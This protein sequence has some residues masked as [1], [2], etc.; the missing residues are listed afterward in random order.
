V[1]RVR[2]SATLLMI[3]RESSGL[4]QSSQMLVFGNKG[5]HFCSFRVVAQAMDAARQVHRLECAR[6][7][8]VLYG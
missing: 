6:A 5:L 4:P 8:L 1:D 3:M 2:S 7:T